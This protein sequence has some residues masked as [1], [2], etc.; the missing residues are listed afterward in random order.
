MTKLITLFLK[1]FP[2]LK[3]KIPLWFVMLWF[4]PLVI[5]NYLHNKTII[6]TQGELEQRKAEVSTLEF[7]LHNL[8]AHAEALE[9]QSKENAAICSERLKD[10]EQVRQIIKPAYV[11][12]TN[13]KDNSTAISNTEA[14]IAAP[15]EFI[16]V[17]QII[18]NAISVEV[19]RFINAHLD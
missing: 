9:Q 3:G 6:N 1:I 14:E 2:L 18:D 11:K 12:Q 8:S 15:L 5:S 10:R 4:I 17:E 19:V 7:R 16:V 13:I